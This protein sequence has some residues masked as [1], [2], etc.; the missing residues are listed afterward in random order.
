MKVD[1]NQRKSL[2]DLKP[3][4]RLCFPLCFLHELLR[5]LQGQEKILNITLDQNSIPVHYQY[6]SYY[7]I[8][9]RW[10]YG[11]KTDEQ[12]TNESR[13]HNLINTFEFPD[14]RPGFCTTVLLITGSAVLPRTIK[15]LRRL[16]RQFCLRNQRCC[17]RT[18]IITCSIS[19]K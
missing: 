19:C 12:K 6:L 14:T 18:N 8:F 4:L 11:S 5:I 2:A 7:F 17:K 15:H 9:H 10:K 3:L 16:N 13:K 1:L